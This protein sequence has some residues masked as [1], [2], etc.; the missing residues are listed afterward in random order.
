[1]AIFFFNGNFDITLTLP[2]SELGEITIP[3]LYGGEAIPENLVCVAP[4]I[5]K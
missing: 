5:R 2:L 1:M 4:V 3:K